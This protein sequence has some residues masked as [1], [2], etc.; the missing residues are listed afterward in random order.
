MYQNS[1]NKYDLN[2]M[3]IGKLMKLQE[4]F[5]VNNCFLWEFVI[6]PYYCLCNAKKG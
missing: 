3:K 2:E 1:E 6:L 4:T 5:I